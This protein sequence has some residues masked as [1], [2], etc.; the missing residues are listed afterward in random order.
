MK[1][2]EFQMEN[3]E[4]KR[5][6]LTV[7]EFMEKLKEDN[8]IDEESK[9]IQNNTYTLTYNGNIRNLNGENVG[10][11]QIANNIQTI[12]LS[13]EGSGRATGVRILKCIDCNLEEGK[14][15]NTINLSGGDIPK[16]L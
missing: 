1:L 13:A 16:K 11:T 9:F 3:I 12:E 4:D 7:S 2:A 14:G 6:K 10:K 15:E 5:N 8:I